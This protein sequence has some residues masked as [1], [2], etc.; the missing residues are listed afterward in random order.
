MASFPLLIPSIMLP[1]GI[2][3]KQYCIRR[4]VESA[5][6]QCKAKGV[7]LYITDDNVKH[8]TRAARHGVLN[9][10]K[11]FQK[12]GCWRALVMVGAGAGGGT[13]TYSRTRGVKNVARL[14]AKRGAG[15]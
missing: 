10:Q 6:D 2:P 9:F 4:V 13:G 3:V 1:C 11:F 14:M 15:N 8:L 12:G 5:T 7:S